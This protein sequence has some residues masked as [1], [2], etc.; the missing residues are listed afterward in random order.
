MVE[1]SLDMTRLGIGMTGAGNSTDVPGRAEVG[2]GGRVGVPR[3]VSSGL[4]VS[5]DLEI[6]H[7]REGVTVRLMQVRIADVQPRILSRRSGNARDQA[8]RESQLTHSDPRSIEHR[9]VWGIAAPEL[10]TVS[11]GRSW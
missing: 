11:N 4:G 2:V 6:I 3:T 5:T 10:W 8:N 7:E 9:A 1:H